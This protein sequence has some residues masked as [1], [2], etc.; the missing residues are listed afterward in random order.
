MVHPTDRALGRLGALPPADLQMSRLAP[1]RPCGRIAGKAACVDLRLLLGIRVMWHCGCE[2][3]YYCITFVTPTDDDYL[4][5]CVSLAVSS[6]L[7]SSW[8]WLVWS[9]RG[10]CVV[11][12]IVVAALLLVRLWSQ[13]S[14]CWAGLVVVVVVVVLVVVVGVLVIVGVV[15]CPCRTFTNMVVFGRLGPIVVACLRCG[16]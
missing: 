6:L 13:R 14:C 12:A 5:A 2:L 9:Q 3:L 16:M 15:V 8:F 10:S 4:C 11:I 1:I 7:F